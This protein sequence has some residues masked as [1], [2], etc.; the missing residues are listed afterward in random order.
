MNS[1]AFD[2]NLP[3]ELI[4]QYPVEPR[5]ASRLMVINRGT[6]VIEHRLFSDLL[7]YL[8]PEDTLVINRTRVIAARLRGVRV[9]TGGRVEVVLIREQTPG[10]WE[11]LL[12]PG[13]RLLPGT[14]LLLEEGALEATVVDKPGSESRCLRFPDGVEVL[15]TL[16]RVGQ[17]PLPPYITRSVNADDRTR[18]QT[19]YADE[20]GA[21][22][23][24]T[25]G[26]HF[27]DR[28]LNSIRQVGV[29]IVPILLHVGP[30]T[31]RPLR[32]ET[33]EE[34]TMEPEY[35]RVE[36][37]ALREIVARRK[38]GRILAVGTTT[39]RTLETIA[40]E[41]LDNADEMPVQD[42]EGWTSCY[43][44][45]PYRFRLVDTLVTN[46]H[47]PRSTLL[48][49]VCAFA[50]REL[51]LSAYEEAVRERYRFY[52]YGDAMLVV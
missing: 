26:L 39:V 41:T 35:Y 24:P 15:E 8:K 38:K 45:P 2:Y 27:T 10:L 29:R 43:I 4:A 12:R 50:G 21:I 17:L 1:A 11:A 22:A 20:P 37:A 34:H 28:L 40:G 9:E 13:A 33:I 47:L 30:G 18:Y 23:A 36:A 25:A 14:K 3:E 32:S 7:T 52:S 5:D 31:F 51:V 48:M 6:G 19:V 46:F 49:L 42:C 44:H 16:E